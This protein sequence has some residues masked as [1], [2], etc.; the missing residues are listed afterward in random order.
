MSLVT[1][2]TQSSVE[3]SIAKPDTISSKQTEKHSVCERLNNYGEWLKAR[4]QHY[5]LTYTLAM[6][7]Y[8]DMF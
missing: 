1:T 8:K 7:L 3:N 2:E 4:E 5:T 6:K